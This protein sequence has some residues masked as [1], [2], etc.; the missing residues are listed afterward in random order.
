MNLSAV[1][2]GAEASCKD[3]AALMLLEFALAYGNDWF[4]VPVD[5]PVGSVTRIDALLITDTFGE[6]LS[7]QSIRNRGARQ[8][9]RVGDVHAGAAHVIRCRESGAARRAASRRLAT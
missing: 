2:L 7:I 1:Q 9:R 4:V 6:R 5:V 3:I 8:R